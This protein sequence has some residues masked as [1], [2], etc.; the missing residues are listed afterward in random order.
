MGKRP[1]DPYFEGNEIWEMLGVGECR[2]LREERTKVLNRL[3][4]IN[5]EK[6]TDRKYC[7]RKVEG[8]MIICRL[9]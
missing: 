6:A 7:T 2:E 8:K 3:R 4:I 1:L 9:N 5:L